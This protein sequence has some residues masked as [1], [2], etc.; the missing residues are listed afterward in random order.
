MK[1]S[2]DTAKKIVL[3]ISKKNPDKLYLLY[4]FYKTLDLY[5]DALNLGSMK[6]NEW[7]IEI[8]KNVEDLWK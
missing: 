3:H 4:W 5:K 1:N 2:G 7:K 6:D 8:H